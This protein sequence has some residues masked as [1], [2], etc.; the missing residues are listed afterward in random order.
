MGLGLSHNVEICSQGEA[1]KLRKNQKGTALVWIIYWTVFTIW[2]LIVA[3]LIGSGWIEND[4]AHQPPPT[5]TPIKVV[6]A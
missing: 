4:P 3:I 6:P 1:M 2:W 5:P